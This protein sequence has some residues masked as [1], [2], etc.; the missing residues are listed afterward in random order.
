MRTFLDYT[1][2]HVFASGGGQDELRAFTMPHLLGGVG[3]SPTGCTLGFRVLAL[4]FRVQG[5]AFHPH[6]SKEPYVQR[7]ANGHEIL[8]EAQYR[9]DQ[10][11]QEGKEPSP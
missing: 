5:S 11:D 9:F 10:D 2:I 8:Q 4:G 6:C 1:N 7:Q 3:K